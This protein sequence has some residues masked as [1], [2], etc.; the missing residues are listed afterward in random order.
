MGKRWTPEEAWEWHRRQPW[1]T[2]CNFVPSTAINQ[3]EMFAEATFDP[4]TID[5][6]LGWA[7][8]IGFNTTRTYLHDLCWRDDR[9]GFLQR[10]DAFLEISHS[11]GIRTLVTIFDDCWHEP[12]AGRQPE[13]RAG[14]HNSGWLRSP[15]RDVLLDRSRWRELEAYVTDLAERFGED[16]RVLAWDVF[17]EVT[18]LFLPSRSL[19][20]DEQALALDEI[21]STGEAQNAASTVLA[22]KTFEWLRAAEVS[23]P[24]TA[25]V[26]YKNDELN[27]RLIGLSDIISFH[28]YRDP[29]SL[30]RFIITLKEQGRPLWCTEYL[31]RR[32]GCTFATHM[33]VFQR[34]G[35][36]CWNWGLVDGKTQ[37]KWAWSDKAEGH[38]ASE[39]AIW[40]HDIFR[41][42]GSPYDSGEIELIR[43]LR[44]QAGEPSL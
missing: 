31:N 24:L 38:E 29:A 7:A 15:G 2:G 23:Q 43:S 34:E 14:I 39:P 11:H 28:H 27:E 40:F 41:A 17:N 6:E 36:G 35:I 33:R 13:P 3:I 44:Q 26:F 5:R 18:N 32:E 8:A 22:E 25:G 20:D 12:T 10:L 1:L 16:D 37:T 4:E 42:D 9:H 30:E 19:P 21:N